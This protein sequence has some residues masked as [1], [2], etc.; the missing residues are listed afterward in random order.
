MVAAYAWLWRAPGQPPLIVAHRGASGL[1]PENTLAA[2]R[3]AIELGAPAVECDVH[4]SADGIPVVIHD[5][6]LDRTT[7]GKG[8][9]AEQPFAA[10][11]TL[12]AGGWRDPRFAGERLPALDGPQWGYP[13]C[14]R[15]VPAARGSSS[16]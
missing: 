16:S 11:Q 6:Q 4:L 13:W 3:L 14:W 7:N 2:F 10:L 1:A 9:V 15:S 5:A 8:P 12:D